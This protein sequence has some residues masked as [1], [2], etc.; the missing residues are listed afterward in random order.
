MFFVL[1][2]NGK[3]FVFDSDTQTWVE[4][5]RG[6]IRLNDMQMSSSNPVFQSRLGQYM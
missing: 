1:Q 3:L 6:T 2:A 4:R 5:G